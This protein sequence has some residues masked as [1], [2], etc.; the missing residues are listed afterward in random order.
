MERIYTEGILFIDKLEMKQERL[1]YFHIKGREGSA[2]P[3]TIRCAAVRSAWSLKPAAFAK[4]HL[5]H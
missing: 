5:T 2:P 3:S 4:F 1:A